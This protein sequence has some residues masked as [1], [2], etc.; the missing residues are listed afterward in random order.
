MKKYSSYY[1]KRK[2][3][4]NKIMK[5]FFLFLKMFYVILLYKRIYRIGVGKLWMKI[6]IKIYSTNK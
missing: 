5:G 4:N 3:K 1:K 6:K 2:E